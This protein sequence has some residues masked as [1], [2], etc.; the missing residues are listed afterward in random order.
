M[1]TAALYD[2]HGNLPALEAVLD[3][4]FRAS[5][6]HIVVGGDVFPG[7]MARECLD[8]L[9][10]LDVPMSFVRGNGER[11]V[12]ERVRGAE[13]EAV[14]EQFRGPLRWHAAEL[15]PGGE[16]LLGG[17]PLT[18][19]VDGV[20][21]CHA[22]PKDDNRI[23]TR[24]TDESRLVDEFSGV[25]ARLVVCGHT[26]MQFDRTLCGA[27]V[28]N[29]GSVGMPFGRPGAYWA[30][31]EE[32]V[33]LR[34]TEYDIA[35]AADRLRASKYPFKEEFVDRFLLDPSSEEDMVA[36]YEKFITAGA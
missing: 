25:S 1:R 22:T 28:V 14:P 21:Y 9:G 6:E 10:S 11:E 32:D 27:R 34:R 23:F 15:G 30:L 16:A 12:F 7:P 17:W 31:I 26:H 8:L 5:V 24:V 13:T 4:A 2:V 20:L 36:R 19:S 29:A 35:A 18:V 33:E 3:E